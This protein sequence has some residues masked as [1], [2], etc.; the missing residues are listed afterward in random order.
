MN[1]LIFKLAT[2][3]SVTFLCGCSDS[4]EKGLKDEIMSEFKVNKNQFQLDLVDEVRSGVLCGRA[5]IKNVGV[6]SYHYNSDEFGKLQ[7]VSLDDRGIYYGSDPKELA[8]QLA[9]TE[10]QIENLK[11]LVVLC[12]K[13]L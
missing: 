12:G 2:V 3:L 1:A 5:R 8:R 13:K 10:G 11:R 4:L 7:W 6:I 9:K